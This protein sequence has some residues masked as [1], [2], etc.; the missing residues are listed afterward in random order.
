MAKARVLIDEVLF[1]RE[2][3]FVAEVKVFEVP[4]SNKFPDGIKVRCVLVNTEIKKPVLLLDNHEPFGF[5]LHTQLPADKNF[6]VPLMTKIYSE[7]IAHFI[8]EATK[9]VSHEEE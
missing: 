1:F 4:A 6:R 7:A 3:R 5:H 9:V 2:G 8:K